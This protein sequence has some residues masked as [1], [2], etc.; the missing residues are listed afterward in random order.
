M[1]WL[2]LLLWLG[3][4]QAQTLHFAVSANS[5]LQIEPEVKLENLDL[6]DTKIDLRLALQESLEFGVTLRQTTSFGPVGNVALVG[7]ADFS[8]NGH[9]QLSLAAEGV[10][11]SVAANLGVHLFKAFPGNFDMTEAFETTRPRFKQGWGFDIGANY[12]LSRNEVIGASP[13]VYFFDEGFAATFEANYKIYKLFEPHDGT[14][15]FQGYLSPAGHSYGAVGFQF[16]LNDKTLPSLAASAYL[17][18]GQQGF[19][20]G[21]KASLSQSFKSSNGKLELNL[22]LE[23][24]RKDFLPY[25]FQASYSQNLG[26]GNLEANIYSALGTNDISPLTFELGY[27]YKF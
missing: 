26:T 5:Y 16:D 25:Y 13:A 11:A 19:L 10:I 8:S 22:G 17:S 7:Q 21:F 1:R 23:P 3:F 27:A 18:L 20:P 15:L 9:Y 12:R 6:N 14:F 4:T 2:W 24:Y